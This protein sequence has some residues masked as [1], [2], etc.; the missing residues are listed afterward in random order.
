MSTTPHRAGLAP[1]WVRPG[2]RG[3]LSAVLV[4]AFAASLLALDEPGQL[5]HRGGWAVLG[6]LVA[7]MLRPDLSPA[8]LPTVAHATALTVAYALCG[9]TVALAVGLPG[10]LLASGVLAR[11]RGLRL[12][13]V[14]ATRGLLGGLRAI[15]ELIWAALFVAAFGLSPWAGVLAIGLPYGATVGRVLAE[16]LQDVPAEPLAA[17][18]SAGASEW[19]ILAYG[20]MPMALADVTSYLFYRLECAVRAAAVLSFVGLGGIGFQITIALDDLRFERVWTLL[21]ALVAV[22]VA[23]DAVSSRARVR[24]TP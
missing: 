4:A 13:S 8:F 12:A 1:A 11:R 18:R 21:F 15:D 2:R 3:L 24:V 23:V 19:Q 22:I 6:D 14:G 7:S 16:R 10:A 5:L 20:R 17:L 9:M